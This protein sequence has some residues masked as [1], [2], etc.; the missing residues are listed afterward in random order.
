MRAQ[1]SSSIGA[2]GAFILF[3]IAPAAV[4]DATECYNYPNTRII[5]TDIGAYACGEWG[6]GCTM[7]ADAQTGG[8][9]VTDGSSCE[10]TPLKPAP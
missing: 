6:W 8:T 10:P 3:L 7:C 1:R 5:E 9:C 4:V 2:V